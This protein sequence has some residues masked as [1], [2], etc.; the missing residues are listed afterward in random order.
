MKMVRLHQFIL[1]Q[2]MG[3]ECRT[4]DAR[5]SDVLSE[6]RDLPKSITM[7]WIRT[8]ICFALLKSSCFFLR[9]SLKM[10]TKVEEFESHTIVSEFISQI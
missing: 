2:S 6:K 7:N 4:F 8:K 10:C 5:L 1:L 3:K 9:G